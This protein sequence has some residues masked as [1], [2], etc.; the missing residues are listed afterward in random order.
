MRAVQNFANKYWKVSTW[1]DEYGTGR[2]TSGLKCGQLHNYIVCI[3]MGSTPRVWRVTLSGSNSLRHKLLHKSFSTHKAFVLKI[4][5]DMQAFR[6]GL[7][8]LKVTTPCGTGVIVG[9]LTWKRFCKIVLVNIGLAFFFY[10]RVGF[11]TWKRFCKIVLVSIGLAFFFY[12]RVK[13]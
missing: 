9:F 8:N 12:R 6:A 2:R 5:W 13:V 10:R 1:A 7:P 4:C 3:L 11:L